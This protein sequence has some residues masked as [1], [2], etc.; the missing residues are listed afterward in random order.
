M[1]KDLLTKQRQ[2]L[3]LDPKKPAPT[4]TPAW[5]AR[6]NAADDRWASGL[7]NGPFF[8]P[9]SR[10]VLATARTASGM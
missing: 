5:Q 8:W 10:D 1:F 6:T 4:E 2:Q 7:G 3:W 9:T